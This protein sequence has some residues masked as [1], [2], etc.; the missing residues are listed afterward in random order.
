MLLY[1]LKHTICIGASN[2]CDYL[3]L[4]WAIISMT[5]VCT[6]QWNVI[7]LFDNLFKTRR[8]KGNKFILGWTT[9]VNC[10]RKETFYYNLLHLSWL[11]GNTFLDGS[12]D[13]LLSD[14]L[15]QFSQLPQRTNLSRTVTNCAEYHNRVER[16]SWSECREEFKHYLT[17]FP[18]M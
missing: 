17:K 6:A 7:D 18:Y 12:S 13:I 4:K 15:F 2:L 8:S 10:K 11:Y 14:Y 9:A 1:Y 16:Y 5:S 3:V